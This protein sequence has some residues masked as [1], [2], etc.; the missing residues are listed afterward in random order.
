MPAEA[1]PWKFFGKQAVV[2]AGALI[3][4]RGIQHCRQGDVERCLG[5][6]GSGW[7]IYGVETGMSE[8]GLVLSSKCES[9]QSHWKGCYLFWP[10]PSVVQTIQGITQYRDYG[11]RISNDPA[12]AM[13]PGWGWRK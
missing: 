8:L 3:E 9:E 10:T 7:T 1:F 2:V 11:P 4:A 5:H 12:S 6:Y 13:Q